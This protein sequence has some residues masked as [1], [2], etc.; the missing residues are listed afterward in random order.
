LTRIRIFTKQALLSFLWHARLGRRR[1][2]CRTARRRGLARAGRRPM[3]SIVTKFDLRAGHTFPTIDHGGSCTS[4]SA[5]YVGS[6]GFDGVGALF[7]H[8]VPGGVP[9]PRNAKPNLSRIIK[10]DQASFVPNGTTLYSTDLASDAYLF[11]PPACADATKRCRLHVAFHGCTQA[12]ETFP[13]LAGFAEWAETNDIVVLF[14][15]ISGHGSNLLTGCW[16]FTGS[17]TSAS[18]YRRDGWQTSTIARLI[19]HLSSGTPKTTATQASTASLA[20]T[21]TTSTSGNV[22]TDSTTTTTTTTT[23]TPCEPACASGQ[24]CVQNKCYAEVGPDSTESSTD[25]SGS[26]ETTQAETIAPSSSAASTTASGTVLFS[27]LTM[28]SI[29]K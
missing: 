7:A 19:D 21:I 17:Y 3:T 23:T 12:G 26:T 29:A 15:Q 13:R 8:I 6:C 9:V 16:D 10:V 24:L 5:P 4:S 20:T 2:R 22:G 27:I 11:L 25:S 1:R 18:F 14:P 28:I